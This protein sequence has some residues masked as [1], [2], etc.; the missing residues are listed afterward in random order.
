M[1]DVLRMTEW[2]IKVKVKRGNSREGKV[3]DKRGGIRKRK[4][5]I[6]ILESEL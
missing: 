3:K 5:K 6:S 4:L 1:E 2:E